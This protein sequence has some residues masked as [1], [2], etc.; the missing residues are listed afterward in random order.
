M[1][2]DLIASSCYNKFYQYFTKHYPMMVTE[3]VNNV[4]HALYEIVELEV[5]ETK[6]DDVMP[7]MWVKEVS[8]AD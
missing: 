1:D 5:R 3:E 4:C 6:T 7:G 2:P 8:C